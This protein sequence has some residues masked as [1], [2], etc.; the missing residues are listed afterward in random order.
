MNLF[1]SKIN[2]LYNGG[3]IS[4]LKKNIVELFSKRMFEK[5][6]FKTCCSYTMLVVDF[7]HTIKEFVNKDEIQ[8]KIS[9]TLV[10]NFKSGTTPIKVNG[11]QVSFAFDEHYKRS[12]LLNQFFC[13][14]YYSLQQYLK[15]F[16]KLL[17]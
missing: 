1:K 8:Y 3:K 15:H 16:Q 5:Y 4:K 14:N 13:C 7:S 2:L 9:R 11:F 6:K 10:T 17:A 12:I